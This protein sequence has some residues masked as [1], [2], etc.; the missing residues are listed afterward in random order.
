MMLFYPL[1]VLILVGRAVNI[2]PLS[3]ML[4]FFRETKISKKNQFI[5]W[6][7]GMYL[8]LGFVAP[9]KLSTRNALYSSFEHELPVNIWQSTH[10]AVMS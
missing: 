2:F 9:P 3:Y 5:M 1:Q 6:Y 10:R 7:S 4:N 8:F